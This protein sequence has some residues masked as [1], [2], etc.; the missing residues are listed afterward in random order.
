MVQKVSNLMTARRGSESMAM[1]QRRGLVFAASRRSDRHTDRHANHHDFSA[2]IRRRLTWLTGR[3]LVAVLTGCSEY[4][5]AGGN[6]THA[7]TDALDGATLSRAET[8]PREVTA[9]MRPVAAAVGMGGT[10]QVG[11][12]VRGTYRWMADWPETESVHLWEAAAGPTRIRVVGRAR[13][14]MPSAGLRG[15]RIRYCV[16][17]VIGDGEMRLTGHKTCSSWT[18]VDGASPA[19]AP[20]AVT[21][22]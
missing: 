3:L 2:P 12:V 17:P 6:Q 22:G 16:K 15:V 7:D 8:A 13:D 10:P 1:T 19:S 21:A 11:R 9:R 5:P 18:T 4:Q 20:A 14:M